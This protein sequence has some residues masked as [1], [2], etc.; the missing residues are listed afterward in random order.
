MRTH[1][2]THLKAPNALET[3]RFFFSCQTSNFTWVPISHLTPPSAISS[4]PH[5]FFVSALFSNI[6]PPQIPSA[7][8]SSTEEA[9]REEKKAA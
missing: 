8:P 6:L 2:S 9:E 1:Q 7:L 4:F 5:L 3:L